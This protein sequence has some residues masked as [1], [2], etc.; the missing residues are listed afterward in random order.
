MS[1]WNRRDIG[2]LRK[3]MVQQ[4]RDSSEIASEIRMRARVSM[5]AAYR[6]AAGLSQPE[7]VERFSE[8]S[9]GVFMDQPLL[10]RLEAFPGPGGRAPL[11]TQIITFATIFE[12]LPLRLLAPEAL[13][14]MEPQERDVLIRCSI[15]SPPKTHADTGQ[16]GLSVPPRQCPQVEARLERQVLMAARR[17]MR[18]GTDAESCNVGP[19]GI[20][21]LRDDVARVASAYP[22]RPLPEL[23]GELAELQEVTFGLLEGRQRPRHTAELYLL[24]GVL[25][26]MLAKASHDL[27]DPHSALTQARTAFICADNIGHDGL[28]AWTAGLRSMISYWASRPNDAVRYAEQG[29]ESAAAASGTASVWL[30]AQEARAWGLL[31]NAERCRAAIQRA[32]EAREAAGRDELDELGGIMTFPTPR[33][34]YYA[35]DAS[36]W[37][38]GAEEHAAQQAEAAIDAYQR[39]ADVDQSFSDEAGARTDLALAR[40][41]QSDV[42]GAAD[43]LEDV[44][45]LPVDQRIEGIVASVRRVHRILREPRLQGPAAMSLQQEIEA[46]TR[47]PAAAALPPGR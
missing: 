10:S 38:P 40:A 6:L 20:D 43:A 46:Y 41:A 4:G 16:F 42:E 26:G 45:D 7:L 24:A 13:D 21:Q 9:P 30:P 5:L 8:A 27:G 25:S 11:A 39:A 29:A 32:K 19:E 47:T 12:V 15:T 36:I 28:K 44:L 23:L 31:G 33:Q 17:A 37:L 2:R 1:A 3:Q 18:F 14:H 34:L 22:Q 35:A